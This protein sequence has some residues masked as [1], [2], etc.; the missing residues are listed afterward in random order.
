MQKSSL[1]IEEGKHRPALVNM[2]GGLTSA[3]ML[4]CSPLHKILQHQNI[5]NSFGLPDTYDWDC[6]DTCVISIGFT[7]V[8][9]AAITFFP[10]KFYDWHFSA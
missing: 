3:H 9:C 2:N 6:V 1:L 4:N 7:P 5:A 10:I 8:Y